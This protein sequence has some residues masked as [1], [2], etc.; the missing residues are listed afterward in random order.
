V[1]ASGW[2]REGA[3]ERGEELVLTEGAAAA[4]RGS[5]RDSPVFK[6]RTENNPIARKMKRSYA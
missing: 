4:E 2:A 3:R 6:P 1:R 5:C